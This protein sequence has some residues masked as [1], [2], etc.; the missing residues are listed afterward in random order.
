MIGDKIDDVMFSDQNI[1]CPFCLDIDFDLIGLKL[2]LLNGHCDKFNETP[3]K[4][5]HRG[6][7]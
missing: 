2:H 1:T 3:I 5:K 4:D 7:N 6:H